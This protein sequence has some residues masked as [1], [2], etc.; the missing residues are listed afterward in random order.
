M[1]VC[2]EQTRA[3]GW[4][5]IQTRRVYVQCSHSPHTSLVWW[6]G[7]KQNAM[8]IHWSTMELKVIFGVSKCVSEAKRTQLEH[9][10][11]ARTHTHTHSTQA[12]TLCLPSRMV[13]KNPK[14]A[15]RQKTNHGH[16]GFTSLACQ[17]RYVSGTICRAQ[18]NDSSRRQKRQPP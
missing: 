14:C 16:V 13:S 3:S 11:F 2:V 18:L 8:N 1:Y 12:H 6:N 9:G 5:E 15:F 17:Q 10:V 7:C 4:S